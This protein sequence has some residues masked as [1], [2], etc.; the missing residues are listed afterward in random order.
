ML[1]LLVA[2]PHRPGRLPDGAQHRVLGLDHHVARRGLRVGERLRDVV[3]RAARHAGRHQRVDPLCGGARAEQLVE[4]R[5]QLAAVGEAGVHRCVARVGGQLGPAG[6]RRQPL[7]E[8]LLRARD[9]DPAVGRRQVLER[10]DG[11]VGRPRRPLRLVPRA[12]VPRPRIRQHRDGGVEQA[13][14]AVHAGAVAPGGV[15]AGQQCHG[16]DQAARE[17]DE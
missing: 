12:Q 13:D 6:G 17:V 5:Q 15:H 10:H 7:P 8:L 11:R 4:R 9:D 2:D 14:V 16:R 1:D 3:H